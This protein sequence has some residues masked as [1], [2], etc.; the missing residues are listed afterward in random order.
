LLG[1]C[2]DHGHNHPYLFGTIRLSCWGRSWGR[3][4]IACQGNCTNLA[5]CRSA[6]S[7]GSG[8]T[9]TAAGSIYP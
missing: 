1:F 7:T 8:A 6:D 5:L 4:G 9:V 2:R 3:L